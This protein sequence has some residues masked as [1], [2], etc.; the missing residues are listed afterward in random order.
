MLVV[1]CNGLPILQ[2]TNNS[3][4]HTPFASRLDVLVA[5]IPALDIHHIGNRGV[6]D[7]AQGGHDMSQGEGRASITTLRVGGDGHDSSCRLPPHCRLSL[8]AARELGEAN[9]R[10]LGIQAT[11]LLK[12]RC[13]VL[14][15]P[16]PPHFVDV[17]MVEEE[18][19]VPTGSDAVSVLTKS[20][21]QR[22]QEPDLR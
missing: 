13:L 9:G 22:L 10:I 3:P 16:I 18:D 12:T 11:D 7:N 17:P 5:E 20:Q 15:L 21:C 4:H 2:K 19:G 1:C 14:G 6:R 8:H